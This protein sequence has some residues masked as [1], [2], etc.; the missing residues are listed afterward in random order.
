MEKSFVFGAGW[1]NLL[2]SFPQIL[3]PS[4]VRLPRNPSFVIRC[5]DSLSSNILFQ[6]QPWQ[7]TAR[8]ANK[9]LPYFSKL[10]LFWK[11]VTFTGSWNYWMEKIWTFLQN[12]LMESFGELP[13]QIFGKTWDFGPTGLT[14]T[15]YL[16]FFLH[17]HI[18]SPGNFT[19][20]KCVNLRQIC[21]ATKQRSL[22]VKLNTECKI[23][24]W[25]QHYTLS[26]KLHTKCKITHQV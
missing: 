19:L 9:Q 2:T 11:C 8:N 15:W 16:S 6:Q 17:A 7:Q 13:K 10:S 24:H 1:R 4:D 18:L 26:V 14:H 22:S 21:P 20:G 3:K 12:L 5:R 23:L 25:V